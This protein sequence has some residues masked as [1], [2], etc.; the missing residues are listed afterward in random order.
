MLGVMTKN[1][2]EVLGVSS[3]A[4]EEE[5][6]KSF[7]KLAQQYHPDKNPNNPQAEAKFKEIAAAYEILGDKDKRA[8]YDRGPSPNFPGFQGDASDIFES[9]FPGFN[10]NFENASKDSLTTLT[11]DFFEPKIT[12]KKIISVNQKTTCG[13]CRGTGAKQGS[14]FRTCSYCQGKGKITQTQGFFQFVGP[15]NSCQGQGRFILENCTPCQ[16]SGRLS[17]DINLEITIPAGIDAG[18]VLRVSGQGDESG[19]GRGDLLIQIQISPHPEFQRKGPHVFSKVNVTYPQA[20]LGDT[21]NIQ[22]IWGPEKLQI[23]KGFQIGD[24]LVL[25][26][27]GFPLFHRLLDDTSQERGDHYILVSLCIPTDLSAEEIEVINKLRKF[28]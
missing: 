25:K 11:L 2:Y 20:V 22:T 23:P 19:K 21:I 16:G 8:Q 18:Q 17:K 12:H 24:P 1:L 28:R 7:R 14:S 27:K 26:K 3:S 5:I 10:F 4:S 15:C 6:K 9:F 13:S